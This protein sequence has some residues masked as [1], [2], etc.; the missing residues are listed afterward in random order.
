MSDNSRTLLR[1]VYA[2]LVP[3]GETFELPAGTQ[4][5]I[6]HRLGGNFTVLS[7]RGL[8][9]IDRKDG[10][11]LGETVPEAAAAAID[12]PENPPAESVLWD[13]LRT[14][15]DPEIPVNLVDL[16]LIYNLSISPAPEGKK[17]FKVHVDMTLTA[18]GCGMG[19]AIAEDARGRLL[20]VPGIVEAD[21]EIVWEPP[22]NQDMISEAGK[23]EL[24]LL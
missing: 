11:A 6:T 8:F 20:E 13:T 12:I 3:S 18:P 10:D 19:P 2:H 4:L 17:G 22:W 5:T 23:M 21:V 7:D 24:G 9:R 1:D 16:G 14:V 15:Y